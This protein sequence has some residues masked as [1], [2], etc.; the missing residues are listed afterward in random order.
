MTTVTCLHC[1]LKVKTNYPESWD[2]YCTRCADQQVD[3][4]QDDDTDIE[5]EDYHHG[6]IRRTSDDE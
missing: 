6:L 2:G 3:G 1:G 5:Y 4:G